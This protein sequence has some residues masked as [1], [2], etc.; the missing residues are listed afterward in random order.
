GGGLKTIELKKYP[1]NVGCD[2]KNHATNKSVTLNDRAPAP[3]FG[4][5]QNGDTNTLASFTLTRT[6]DVVRAESPLPNGIHLIKEYRLSTNYLVK[7]SVRYENR[8][9]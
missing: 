9:A 6:G 1:S 7:A 4:I 5:V 3:V 8:G 2:A